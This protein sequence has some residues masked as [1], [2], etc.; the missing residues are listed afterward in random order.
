MRAQ[1]LDGFTSE[2][3]Q[4]T[5]ISFIHNKYL[6]TLLFHLLL[7]TTYNKLK[8]EINP[9]LGSTCLHSS[10]VIKAMMSFSFCVGFMTRTK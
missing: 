9:D 1:L 2:S 4:F 5:T 8:G 7:P 3:N 10:I 6:I